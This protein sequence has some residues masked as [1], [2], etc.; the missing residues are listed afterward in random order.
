MTPNELKVLDELLEYAKDLM[1]SRG[2]N[3]IDPSVK[4]LMTAPEWNSLFK[5]I[6]KAELEAQPYEGESYFG[7][8]WLVFIHLVEKLKKQALNAT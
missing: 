7:C 1:S 5:E 8:D 6:H 3:D 4:K 2:C